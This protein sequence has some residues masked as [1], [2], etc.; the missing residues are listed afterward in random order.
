M[1]LPGHFLASFWPLAGKVQD[2]WPLPSLFLAS[3]WPLAGKALEVPNSGFEVFP[4]M[5]LSQTISFLL[6]KPWARMVPKWSKNGPKCPKIAQDGPKMLPKLH[7][8]DPIRF[9]NDTTPRQPEA[10]LK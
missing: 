9:Q 8:H 2:S 3:S 4:N 5:H 10:P 7:Q 1:P 6:S